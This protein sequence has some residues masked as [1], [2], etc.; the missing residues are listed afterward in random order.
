MKTIFASIA[1][2]ILVPCILPVHANERGKTVRVITASDV[3]FEAW[4]D[5]SL[6]YRADPSLPF[7]YWV[8]GD[9]PIVKLKRSG[10]VNEYMGALR[11]M[12]LCSNR[13]VAKELARPYVYAYVPPIEQRTKDTKDE[14]L[15]VFLVSEKEKAEVADPRIKS[16]TLVL[17]P[18][19][20]QKIEYLCTRLVDD[21]INARGRP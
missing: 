11:L 18:T 1:V 5:G 16:A 6:R 20:P 19:Y 8:G 2:V 7:A 4:F 3:G 21:L 9:L 10:S 17:S 15:T 12:N 13:L 14:V